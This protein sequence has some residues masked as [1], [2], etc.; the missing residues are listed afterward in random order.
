MDY[1]PFLR[2]VLKDVKWFYDQGLPTLVQVDWFEPGALF[3]RLLAN[4]LPADEV[5]FLHGGIS[6]KKREPRKEAFISGDTKV[7]VATPVLSEGTD[8]PNIG[9]IALACPGRDPNVIYQR[10]G[11]GFRPKDHLYMTVYWNRRHRYF[12]GHAKAQ[13]EYFQKNKDLYELYIDEPL[14][15]IDGKA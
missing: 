5:D 11:R 2:Q 15:R 9:A 13:L 6:A 14:R 7:I 8:L 10:A 1:R 12:V 3:Y 4:L